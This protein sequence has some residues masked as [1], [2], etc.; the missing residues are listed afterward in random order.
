MG[1]KV[2]VVGGGPGG[3]EA[4]LVAGDRGHK[5]VLFEKA[6]LGGQFN[7]SIIPPG[8]EMMKRPLTSV[9][10]RVKNSSIDFIDSGYVSDIQESP[11]SFS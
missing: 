9:R 10:I 7:L 11:V 6:D 2:V 5:V 4:A 8:K 1:K 3:M